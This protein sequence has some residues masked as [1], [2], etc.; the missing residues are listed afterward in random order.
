MAHLEEGI[1]ARLAAFAALTALVPAA[2]ITPAPLPEGQLL[3][4]VTFQKLDGPR[5]A[6][7]GDDPGLSYP[8]IQVTCY[9]KDASGKSRLGNALDVAKQVRAALQRFRGT[10]GGVVFQ[11]IY[12]EDERDLGDEGELSPMRAYAIDFVAWHQES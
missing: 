9:A 3:P 2:R 12:L 11:D 7:M 10:A 4:A 1:Y 5:V 6:A 8:R